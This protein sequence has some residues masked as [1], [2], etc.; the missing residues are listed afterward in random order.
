ML[1]R[2]SGFANV[3]AGPAALE[4]SCLEDRRPEGVNK[5][6]AGQQGWSAGQETSSLEAWKAGWR[7]AGQ[8]ANVVNKAAVALVNKRIASQRGRRTG[9]LEPSSLE[10]WKAGG[11]LARVLR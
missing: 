3:L 2:Q 4:T 7:L 5:R 6:T 8:N 1:G 9:G 10:A 11:W